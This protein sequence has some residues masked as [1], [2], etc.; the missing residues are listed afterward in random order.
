MNIYLE[1]SEWIENLS[2]NMNS[3]DAIEV[4]ANT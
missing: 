3:Q 1:V 2:A 4:E